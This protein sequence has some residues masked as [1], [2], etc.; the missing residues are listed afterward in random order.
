MKIGGAIFFVLFVSASAFAGRPL[1][2]D[3][4][5]PVDQG[6]FEF[7]IG[8]T[9]VKYS[10][11]RHWD[12]PVGLTYGLISDVEVGIGFG[13]QYE[14]RSE[15]LHESGVANICEES[16]IGDLALGAKWQ[17]V[18]E[19]ESMPRQ[20]LVPSVKFPT[21][22]EENGLGSGEMDFDLTWIASFSFKDKMGAHF[23]AG[24]TWIGEPTGE[25]VGNILHYGLAADYQIFDTVQLVGEIFA[26]RELRGESD[27]AVQYSAGFRW[28]PVDKLTLDIAGGS[29]LSGEA[30]D[31]TVA[32]GLTL[33]FGFNNNKKQG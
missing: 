17:F 24:Y 11:C 33:A 14:T 19:S 22:D 31:F 3:D 27:H 26:E 32:A 2:I 30:P 13:G 20:A 8:E 15:F 9:H 29:R 23:N 7:E 18:K 12:Y 28:S 16:G 4:A 5:D 6:Q 10:D 1:T 21:A 25:D